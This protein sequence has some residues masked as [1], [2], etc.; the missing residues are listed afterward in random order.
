MTST[1]LSSTPDALAHWDNACSFSITNNSRLL[2]NLRPLQP[3]ISIGGVGGSCL[4]THAGYLSILPSIN[5]MNLALYSKDFPQTLLSLGHIH[6]CGGSYHT[7]NQ[8][9]NYLVIKATDTVILDTSPLNSNSNLSPVSYILLNSTKA[10]HP[11]L[12]SNISTFRFPTGSLPKSLCKYIHQNKLRAFSAPTNKLLTRHITAAQLRRAQEALDLHITQHHPTDRKLALELSSGKHPYSHL[13]AAD[14]SLMRE[15][16]G[17][18]PHCVEGRSK[19]L[20][21]SRLTSLTAPATSPGQ[22][23]SLDPQKL[24]YPAASSY[25]HK[26]TMVDEHSGHIS[27][28]GSTSKS[29][30]AIFNSINKVLQVTYNANNHRVQSLHT[31]AEAVCKSLQPPFGI[32]GITVKASLPG[33]HAARAERS[34]ST[35][36]ERSRATLASLPYFL[37][38]E[39]LLRLDQSVGET[40]NNSICRAS[41]PLT[42]NEIISGFKPSRPPVAFGR[43]AMVL[44]STDKRTDT[45]SKT[46]LPVKSI[47]LTEIGVS[48]GLSPGSNDTLFLLANGIIVPRK[49]IGP[50]LLPTYVPFGWKPKP[51]PTSLRLQHF[52]TILDPTTPTPTPPNSSIQLPSLQLDTALSLQL[53][54][55]IAVPAY[56]PP[57]AILH[58]PRPTA[59]Q[60]PAA[61]LPAA[62]TSTAPTATL[63]STQFLPTQPP[64]NISTTS[65]PPMLPPPQP[66]APISVPS[67]PLQ[68]S[69]TQPTIATSNTRPTRLRFQNSQQGDIKTTKTLLSP[70]KFSSSPSSF[71]S[72]TKHLT[73]HLLRKQAAKAAASIRDRQH[74]LTHPP[75][76]DLNNRP[77]DA[78]PTP[79]PRQKNEFTLKQSYSVLDPIKIDQSIDKELNKV[80]FKWCS[81]KPISASQVEPTSIL[82]RSQWIVKEKLNKDVSS[83]VVLNGAMQP[84]STYSDTHASTSDSNHRA[85]VLATALADAAHRN[86]T[87]ITFSA[88]IEAAFINNN[89]LPRSK[90]GG[91]QLLTRLPPGLP[92]PHNNALCEVTGA[93]Y[94]LKQSNNIYDQNLLATLDSHGYTRCPSHPYTL[95]KRSTTDLLDHLDVSFHVD[96]FEGCTT[97]PIL[98]KEF[99]SIISNRYGPT[100]FNSPSKGICG[101]TLEVNADN[102]IKVHYGPYINKMLTRIGM[103]AVPAALSPDIEGLF[104]PSTDP[105]PLSSVDSAEFRTVNGELIFILPLRHDIKKTVS[106]ILTKGEHPD[107]SDYKK[108]LHLLRYLKGTPNHGPTFSFSKSDF[109]NGVEIHSASDMAHNVYKEDGR[110]HGAYTLTVGK[111]GAQTAPFLSYS[112]KEKGVSLSPAEGEYV[113]LSRTA[114]PLIHYRQFATDL[115]YPQLQPSIMLEDNASAIKLTTTP[116]IPSKSRHIDLKHHHVRWA[117]QTKQILPQHQGTNDIVPDALTKHV[118]PSRFLYFRH[119]VF[120]PR[121]PRTFRTKNL[122]VTSH[123]CTPRTKNLYVT[124]PSTP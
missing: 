48:M 98:Y 122:C 88:D 82:L 29:T 110:S 8:P 42:P 21:A 44:Q 95:T 36:Q 32:L 20:A 123:P 16:Q 23:I 94:G 57:F 74:L 79:P 39:L 15:L 52:S 118:G 70:T 100:T 84:P 24:P 103:D 34:T 28:P 5:H 87:L 31:D 4:A 9:D 22:T 63:P 46:G 89:P 38:S 37:P 40:L 64:D 2:S 43:V 111:V 66:T 65:N 75:P 90:T 119:Q 73:G 41:A 106:F 12:Y 72:H 19:R 113:T 53:P 102:S 58:T 68:P 69:P 108:Q 27:Q 60:P 17:P 7:T 56:P 107:N 91:T 49:P 112:S 6:R 86:K 55:T 99:Q 115:G 30:K 33:E 124:S 67:S 26:V 120:Q 11:T 35:I 105:T 92:P 54:S 1:S 85:F 59:H 47:G 96:D 50:L 77:T 78:L 71:L 116:I 114:K 25:T 13:T 93:H 97:C 83:R 14:I 10:S 51:L 109:P 121:T 18:C 45:S 61:Q 62:Q 3:P 104:E 81:L 76:S 80:L 101:Q 117:Y